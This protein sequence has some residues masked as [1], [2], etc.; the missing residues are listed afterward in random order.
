MQAAR[1]RAPKS[2]NAAVGPWN[3]SSTCRRGV[4]SGLS[5]A[6]NV[7]AS[8]TDR[9]QF[10]GERIAS[11]ERREQP[12]RRWQASPCS[13]QSP[14]AQISATTAARTGRHRARVRRRLR[15]SSPVPGPAD[16]CLYTSS[17]DFRRG[18]VKRRDEALALAARARKSLRA[19]PV[20]RLRLP[21]AIRTRRTRWGRRRRCSHPSRHD[22]ARPASPARIRRSA[23][24]G[25]VRR[26][27][28]ADPRARGSHRRA[29][30]RLS[31]RA[32]FALCATKSQ[33]AY[34]PL[35]ASRARRVSS[36]A[37]GM[38]EHAVPLDW[39]HDRAPDVRRSPARCRRAASGRRCR[40]GV[41]RWRPLR[42]RARTDRAAPARSGL[43]SRAFA[44]TSA[45][46][47]LAAEPPMPEPNAM[48]LSSSISKPNGRFS[49]C[50]WRSAP[51]RRCSFA[52]SIGRSTAQPR[53]AAMRTC[54][55]LC[56]THRCAVAR[57]DERL[58]EN[59]EADAE[60]ADAG[61]RKCGCFEPLH[62]GI[63]TRAPNEA[64]TR[65]RSA[66]TPAAV[67]SGPAPGPCT[68][69]GLSQ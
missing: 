17:Q 25:A 34:A 10:G 45:A 66:K 1:K 13:R 56:A 35:S 38:H 60:I 21:R 31:T 51:H 29:G 68:T 48:P 53:I 40:R 43:S 23:V 39:H 32:R 14:A 19:S 52:A 63:Q 59:I 26:G 3:S 54:L 41:R 5:G 9:R 30:N 11:E 49:A 16:V 44:A 50:A 22:R 67:T 2:L 15:H 24:R 37:C 47:Q 28:R 42:R 58:A 18:S 6:R 61:G 36:T 57:A 64:A 7:N 65:S 69:S 46:T 27:R 62:A 12:R 4:A 8:A 55:R 33:I 20:P